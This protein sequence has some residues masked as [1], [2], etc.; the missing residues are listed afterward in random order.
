MT[1][2]RLGPVLSAEAQ[3]TCAQ[4]FGRMLDLEIMFHDAPYEAG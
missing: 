2:D 3:E 1:I 4:T